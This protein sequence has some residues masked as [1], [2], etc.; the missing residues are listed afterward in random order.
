[1][2]VSN[3]KLFNVTEV[4]KKFDNLSH[5]SIKDEDVKDGTIALYFQKLPNKS[6]MKWLHAAKYNKKVIHND[7]EITLQEWSSKLGMDFLTTHKDANTIECVYGAA[8][9]IIYAT[10]LEYMNG[11]ILEDTSSNIDHG[12]KEDL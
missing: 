11:D 5:E 6:T 7:E 8:N 3:R 12:I 1:M 9:V 10:P 4:V 2:S